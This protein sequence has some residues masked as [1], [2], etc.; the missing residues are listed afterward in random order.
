MSKSSIQMIH[1]VDSSFYLT[2]AKALR[3]CK[4]L[5]FLDTILMY[6]YFHKPSRFRIIL[7][8]PWT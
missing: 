8:S 3:W 5:E 7:L 2:E 6:V 1:Q 4:V